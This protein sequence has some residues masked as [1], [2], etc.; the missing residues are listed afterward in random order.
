M[1]LQEVVCWA[2]HELESLDL[3]LIPCSRSNNYCFSFLLIFDR[4]SRHL[5][6]KVSNFLFSKFFLKLRRSLLTNRRQNKDTTFF[7]QPCKL[8]HSILSNSKCP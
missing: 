3:F 8:I 5:S 1:L 2:W 4:V 7:Y 6:G